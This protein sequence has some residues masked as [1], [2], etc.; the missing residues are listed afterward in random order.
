MIDEL[1]DELHGGQYFSKLDLH[2]RYHHIQV[3]APNIL[4]T[5]FRIHKGTITSWWLT[6]ASGL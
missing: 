5:A 2:S 6:N 1:L 4:K 3:H